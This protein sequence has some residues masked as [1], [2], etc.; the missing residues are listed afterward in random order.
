MDIISIIGRPCA[1]KGTQID[2]LEKK[3][4]FP[5]MRTGL[6][7]R[8]RAKE[9]DL[10]GRKIREVYQ[11]GLLHPTPIVFSIWTP[12]LLNVKE[13]SAK[14]VIFDGNPR[15][16]YEAHMLEELF[17]VLDW[18]DSWRVFYLDISEKEAYERMKKRGREYDSDE[19][20]KRRLEWFDK[21][22][23]PVI[24]Y[25]EKKNALVRIDGRGTVEEVWKDVESHI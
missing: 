14:G 22:V 10:L 23:S 11:K 17:E 1:G 18:K 2:L 16:L 9:D 3:T 20:I 12:F 6:L 5:V 13:S 15:K 25:F 21:E 24:D 4:S 7:L 8:E 19:E